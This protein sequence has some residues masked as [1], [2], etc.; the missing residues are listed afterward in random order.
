MEKQQIPGAEQLPMIYMATI[1]LFAAAR[2][3]QIVSN[4]QAGSTGNLAVVTL[5]MNAAGTAARVFTS[6]QEVK[7]PVIF[8]G[9]VINAGLNATLLLQAVLYWS[10]TAAALKADEDAKAKK[11]D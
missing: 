6:S 3:P 8:Y 9:A 5:F 2:V 10:A 1:A 11:D 4:F 7:D